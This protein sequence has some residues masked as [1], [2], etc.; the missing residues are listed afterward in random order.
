MRFINK[1]IEKVYPAGA[2]NF[3]EPLFVIMNFIT[4]TVNYLSAI[5]AKRFAA[6][7]GLCRFERPI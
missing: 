6:A 5:S 4:F 7:T 3:A 2:D 1:E